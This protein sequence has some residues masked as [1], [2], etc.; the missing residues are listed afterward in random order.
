[1][2]TVQ[3]FRASFGDEQQCGEQLSRQRWPAGFTCPRCGE[4]SRGYMAER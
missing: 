4:P 2:M 1:M 3:Q